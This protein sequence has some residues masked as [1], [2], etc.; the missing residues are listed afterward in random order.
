MKRPARGGAPGSMRRA[1]SNGAFD[2]P[3][4]EASGLCDSAA[5][6]CLFGRDVQPV[7]NLHEPQKT[8]RASV[9]APY[10]VVKE[11]RAAPAI[12]GFHLHG[13]RSGRSC[14]DG[15]NRVLTAEAGVFGEAVATH[16]SRARGPGRVN[17]R[18][19]SFHRDTVP[20]CQHDSS[21]FVCCRQTPV[22]GDGS[23]CD[24]LATLV[25]GVLHGPSLP[26]AP[27]S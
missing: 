17:G 24:T 3:G 23:G 15:R 26:L 27:M 13:R 18:L 8:S 16:C 25:F 4:P 2:S 6:S 9:R 22:V 5:E 11:S 10:A 19:A 20:R 7:T 12:T 14:F 1:G 21:P